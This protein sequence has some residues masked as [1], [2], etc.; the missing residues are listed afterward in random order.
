[1]LLPD[2]FFSSQFL[3]SSLFQ[4]YLLGSWA[5]PSAEEPPPPPTD[6]PTDPAWKALCQRNAWEFFE[7]GMCDDLRWT[8]L[9]FFT[10]FFSV[11]STFLSCSPALGS[12]YPCCSL[13]PADCGL[14]T[15]QSFVH[16]FFNY[17][18]VIVNRQKILIP[19]T[20]RRPTSKY[21]YRHK[22]EN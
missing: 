10:P 9:Y 3:S 18:I 21:T 2:Y 17:I 20:A 15:L 6:R 5:R 11:Y 16:I 19:N 14:A 12:A 7:K 22:I 13:F 8:R 4:A 1:M